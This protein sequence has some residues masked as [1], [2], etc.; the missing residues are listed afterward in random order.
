[1]RLYSTAR[2]AVLFLTVT[3]G[4]RAFSPLFVKPSTTTIGGTGIGTGTGIRTTTTKR[5]AGV[6]DLSIMEAAFTAGIFAG[7]MALTVVQGNINKDDSNISSSAAVVTAKV[8]AKTEEPI[9]SVEE[10]EP[11]IVVPPI[12]E[13]E[14]E[15]EPVLVAAAVKEPVVA[16]PTPTTITQDAQPVAGTIETVSSAAASLLNDVRA[17]A[18]KDTIVDM[19]REVATT[20][21][22]VREVEDRMQKRAVQKKVTTQRLSDPEPLAVAATTVA[23]SAAAATASTTSKEGGSVVAQPPPQLS[24]KPRKQFNFFRLLLRIFLKIIMPWK[25]WESLA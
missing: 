6:G 14:L 24:R 10:P 9:L 16:A 5:D 15:P 19:R 21:D 8:E 23:A 2:T 13:P 18:Q 25:K 11:E 17:I 20:L 3:P 22:Q 1:M 12:P 7:S 4:S